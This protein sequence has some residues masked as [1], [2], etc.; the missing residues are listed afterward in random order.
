[1]STTLLIQ[2]NFFHCLCHDIRKKICRN[3]F[4]GEIVFF[5]SVKFIT[6]QNNHLNIINIKYNLTIYYA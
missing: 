2:I 6:K 4:N 5:V 1:M 3:L